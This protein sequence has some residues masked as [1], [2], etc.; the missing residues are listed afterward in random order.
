MSNRKTLFSTCLT[1]GPIQLFI[2]FTKELHAIPNYVRCKLYLFPMQCFGQVRVFCNTNLF[3]FYSKAV[4]ARQVHT[5]NLLGSRV[6]LLLIIFFHQLK[7][8][9]LS[10]HVS[11][12]FD[13]TH[14]NFIDIDLFYISFLI[15][16]ESITLNNFL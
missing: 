3:V 4:Q 10:V 5:L 9:Q 13:S 15:F 6:S 14:L 8:C 11:T 12:S 16:F 7:M 1:V 2:S